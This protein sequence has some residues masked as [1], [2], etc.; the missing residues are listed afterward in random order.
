MASMRKFGSIGAALAKV[1]NTL[2]GPA[3]D[4]TAS[5]YILRVFRLVHPDASFFLF[6]TWNDDEKLTYKPTLYTKNQTKLWWH[7]YHPSA[8]AESTVRLH[9][10]A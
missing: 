7:Q 8:G 3:D 5:F 9:T 4:N 6:V 2:N 10:N 1:F